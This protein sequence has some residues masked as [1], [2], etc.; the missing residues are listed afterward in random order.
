MCLAA[1]LSALCLVRWLRFD[2]MVEESE[3]L[4]HD[5][6]WWRIIAF[7]STGRA[8]PHDQFVAL[9]FQG[10]LQRHD[11]VAVVHTETM[12]L[13]REKQQNMDI[14]RMSH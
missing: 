4:W 13:E 11:F 8:Y 6:K 5:G 3:H 2:M 14:E 10:G 7:Q 9:V 12:A 1:L